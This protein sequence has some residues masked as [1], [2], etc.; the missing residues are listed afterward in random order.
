[1]EFQ[2]KTALITGGAVRLGRAIALALAEKGADIV[3]H[4]GNSE[5]A[6]RELQDRLRA[7]GVS[8]H[9]VQGDLTSEA[10]CRTIMEQAIGAAGRLDIL[11]NNAAAFH[12]DR[13]LSATEEGVLAEFWPNL[14]APLFLIRAFATHCDHGR[15]VNMLDRRITAHDTACVPYMLAKKGLEELTHLAALELAPHFAVNAVAP[16]VLLPPPGKDAGYL[17]EHGGPV[18]LEY[19]C[20]EADISD[21]VLY[22]LGSDALTGQI[23]FVDGGK[24]LLGEST[25]G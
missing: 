1:M 23:I 15:I 9:R 10:A 22:L 19:Q 21:A 4:Y 18:P 14:F 12:R 16:G 7:T 17:K 13:L 6:A 25:Y 5:A 11:V 24:H 20:T 2:G 3:I 8:S